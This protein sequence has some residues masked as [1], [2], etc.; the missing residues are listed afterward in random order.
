MRQQSREMGLFGG[1]RR[2]ASLTFVSVVLAACG[3]GT[4]AGAS[5][6]D[7]EKQCESH[8]ACG[9]TPGT[10]CSEACA[11]SASSAQSNG[12]TAELDA[13]YACLAPGYCTAKC[14]MQNAAY[15]KCISR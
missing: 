12:C 9:L 4:S 7:C 1:V 8:K 2:V 3:S 10:S 11:V 14:D 5:G 13:W 15:G 6:G